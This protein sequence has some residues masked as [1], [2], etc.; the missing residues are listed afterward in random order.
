MVA[1]SLDRGGGALTLEP[2]V[3]DATGSRHAFPENVDGHDQLGIA[4]VD[5]HPPVTSLVF[6][7][8]VDK[9]RGVAVR[10]NRQSKAWIRPTEAAPEIANERLTA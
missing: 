9:R 4:H 2:L 1:E 10:H 7:H 6:G 5:V 3:K 8:F